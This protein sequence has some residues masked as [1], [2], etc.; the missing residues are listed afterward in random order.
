MI[1][2]RKGFSF[3]GFCPTQNKEYS[4]T[5][6]FTESMSEYVQTGAFCDFGSYGN[7]PIMNECPIRNSV[8]ERVPK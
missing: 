1:N 8:F 3:S 4:I 5:V 6:F 2:E 7:C